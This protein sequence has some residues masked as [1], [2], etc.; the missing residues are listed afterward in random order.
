MGVE[1]EDEEGESLSIGVIIGA[2]VGGL[3]VG[4]LVTYIAYKKC[5]RAA[6]KRTPYHYNPVELMSF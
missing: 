4:V 3:A 5:F 2:V 6:A 1:K